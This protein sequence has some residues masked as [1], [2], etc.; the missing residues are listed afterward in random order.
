MRFSRLMLARGSRAQQAAA[1]TAKLR[2]NSSQSRVQAGKIFAKRSAVTLNSRLSTL[3]SPT[4]HDSQIT[5]HI[6]SCILSRMH[7]LGY[8]REH[9][10]EF[11][12]MAADRGVSIDFAAFRAIDQERRERITSAEKLKA[13]RNKASEE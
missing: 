13:Q 2:V 3:N 11:E 7:D 8:F 12:K 5:N 10:A 9:L 6:S 4:N 1:S